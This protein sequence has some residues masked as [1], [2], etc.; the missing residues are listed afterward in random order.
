M[1][2]FCPRCNKEITGPAALSGECPID[3]DAQTRREWL[4]WKA[5]T[6]VASNSH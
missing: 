3:H 2:L 4:E 5:L 6:Y 1:K